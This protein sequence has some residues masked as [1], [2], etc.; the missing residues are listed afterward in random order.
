MPKDDPIS[1]YASLL[2]KD[3]IGNKYASGG[4][5]DY[6]GPAWVDGSSTRPEAFLSADDTELMRG[7]LDSMSYVKT[8]AYSSNIDSSMFTGGGMSIENLDI[9]ITEAEFKEDADYEKVA[10]RV[11][12]AFVKELNRQGLATANYSF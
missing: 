10:Q 3:I 7:M 5:V 1:L 6:T 11:G 12:E 4:L 9:T 8:H 2:L